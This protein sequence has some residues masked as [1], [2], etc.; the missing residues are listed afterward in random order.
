MSLRMLSVLLHKIKK[1]K[2]HVAYV[3][4]KTG[5]LQDWMLQ[6][7]IRYLRCVLEQ[8]VKTEGPN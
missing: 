3:R 8:P 2:R 7:L 4:G 1:K 5:T 6:L